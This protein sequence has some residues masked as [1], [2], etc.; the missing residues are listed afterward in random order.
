MEEVPELAPSRQTKHLRQHVS[1]N[2]SIRPRSHA[3]ALHYCF[4]KPTHSAQ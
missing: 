2:A 3:V 4:K 1:V